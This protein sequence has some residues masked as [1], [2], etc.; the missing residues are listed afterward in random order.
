MVICIFIVSREV[1]GSSLFQLMYLLSLDRILSK[2]NEG[3]SPY[4]DIL[5]KTAKLNMVRLLVVF[6]SPVLFVPER[7]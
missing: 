1:R 3:I 7:F 2:L 4:W 6:L 5:M